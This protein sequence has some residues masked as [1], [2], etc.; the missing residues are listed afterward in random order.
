MPLP[1][2]TNTPSLT[3]RDHLRSLSDRVRDH[4]R[5]QSSGLRIATAKDDAAGLAI[6][7]RLRAQIAGYSQSTQNVSYGISLASTAEAGLG[8]ISDIVG[9]LKELS[10][11][12]KNGT[13]SDADKQSLQSEADQLVEQIDQIAGSSS[14]NGLSLLDGSTSS[15]ELDVGG[16]G[17]STSIELGSATASS[18]GL[19]GF[20]LDGAG[21]A[22]ALSKALEKVSGYQTKL[23]A[24]ESVLGHTVGALN[25]QISSLT[26]EES[27]IRDLDYAESQSLLVQDQ[28]K[29]QA[30]LSILAQAN[31]S[32]SKTLPLL[33]Q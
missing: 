32:A 18:L 1:L 25:A 22:D 2:N 21:A 20:D 23:G 8:Q 26:A 29:S 15:V 31:L 5:R 7:E 12:A 10:V 13:L 9:K 27:R 28:V 6:S 11:Q 4:F 3:A 14:F 17:S 24:A 30:S 33:S 16:G 19:S